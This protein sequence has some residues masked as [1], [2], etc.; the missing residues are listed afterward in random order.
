MNNEIGKY[1]DFE[2]TKDIKESQLLKISALIDVLKVDE[3]FIDEEG[4]KLKILKIAY[5]NPIDDSDDGI[6][7]SQFAR[8]N[9]YLSALKKQTKRDLVKDIVF[10]IM[11]VFKI[12]ESSFY[13]F[14]NMCEIFLGR[15]VDKNFIIENFSNIKINED[16]YY[17][18]TATKRTGANKINLE[19][20]YNDY[21]YL[22][23][24]CLKYPSFSGSDF[25]KIY[26][27]QIERIDKIFAGM[28]ADF[29]QMSEEE[30]KAINTYFELVKEKEKIKEDL[31]L[32]VEK[33]EIIKR[34]RL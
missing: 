28:K 31:G 23:C 20:K 9:A 19:F 29:K 26:N 30:K 34:K 5:E 12:K 14:K 25:M 22:E 1:I 17:K 11:D 10:I 16:G 8:R 32:T 2:I 6:R 24:F 33:P 27:K 18:K 3:T 15:S 7:K 13:F 21:V 4:L